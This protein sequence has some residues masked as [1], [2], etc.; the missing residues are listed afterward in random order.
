MAPTIRKTVIAPW[1]NEGAKA[2]IPPRE[3]AVIWGEDPPRD[4]ILEAIGE[5]GR[6]GWKDDSGHPWRSL[7]E[8]RK[9]RL[10][11]LGERMFSRSFER[12]ECCASNGGTVET[13]HRHL[14]RYRNIITS[15]TFSERQV[16]EAHV[17]VALLNRF[18]YL[19]I[20]KSAR[21]E[22]IASAA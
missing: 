14:M 7:A 20:P 2:A 12:R 9:Y 11:R 17:R 18:A 8:N 4:A 13:P 10:K 21:T 1:P 6:A 15:V 5:H 22:Q 3:G 16:S 19:R